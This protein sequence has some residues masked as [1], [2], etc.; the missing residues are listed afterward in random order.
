LHHTKLPILFE[1]CLF[2][3]FTNALMIN[4]ILPCLPMASL[5]LWHFCQSE[6]IMVY[7]SEQECYME[8]TR[9]C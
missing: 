5:M 6:Q 2:L 4:H 7:S 8:C 9:D 3:F 1:G